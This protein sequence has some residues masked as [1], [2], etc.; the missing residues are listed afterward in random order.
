MMNILENIPFEGA[1][2]QALR[3]HLEKTRENKV[4]LLLRAQTWEET[5]QIR[6]AIAVLD[7]LLALDKPLQ[8][9]R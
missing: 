3:L 7:Q 4:G 2:W 6:G 8:A 9:S 1:T 5:N